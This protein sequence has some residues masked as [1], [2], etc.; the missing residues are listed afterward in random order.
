MSDKVLVNVHLMF[1]L[2][3]DLSWLVKRHISQLK[4]LCRCLKA[5]CLWNFP[6]FKSQF[7]ARTS[8]SR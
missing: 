1:S 2:A 4:R 6:L 8:L 5:T 7:P 3:S